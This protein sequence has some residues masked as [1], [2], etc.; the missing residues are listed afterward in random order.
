[1]LE[2]FSENENENEE[3]MYEE[4][5]GEKPPTK[6]LSPK[7][8][9]SKKRKAKT[10]LESIVDIYNQHER[11]VE[12]N[13]QMKASVKENKQMRLSLKKLLAAFEELQ[14]TNWTL[15]QTLELK[16]KSY[17]IKILRLK[18]EMKESQS[19]KQAWL[20]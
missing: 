14:T 1:M 4:A 19:W 12:E 6:S 2:Q 8:S 16:L 10:G 17:Q 18:T 7:K 20:K 13:K 9:L 5:T 11:L 3:D 15:K